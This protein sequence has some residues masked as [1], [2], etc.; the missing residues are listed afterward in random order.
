MLFGWNL[1]PVSSVYCI[2]LPP[3]PGLAWARHLFWF[4]VPGGTCS[5]RA[6]YLRAP[7]LR[8]SDTGYM[9]SLPI[10]LWQLGAGAEV[11]SCKS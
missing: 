10:E 2:F 8:R 7:Q 9:P 11:P 4:L 1:I 5:R 6:A 3:F